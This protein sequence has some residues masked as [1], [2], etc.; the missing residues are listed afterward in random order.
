[1]RAAPGAIIGAAFGAVFLWLGGYGFGEKAGRVEGRREQAELTPAACRKMDDIARE[2]LDNSQRAARGW[3]ECEINRS[4][5]LNAL[6][7]CA[8]D[9]GT[10]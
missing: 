5:L 7:G 9:G 1:M 10:P 2:A 6:R 8:A 3:A 4:V